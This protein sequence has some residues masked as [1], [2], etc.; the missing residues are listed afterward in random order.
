MKKLT[1]LFAFF[2]LWMIPEIVVSQ[3]RATLIL[4][5]LDAEAGATIDVPITVS[6]SETIA[7][8]QFV[9]EYNSAVLTFVSAELGSATDGFS[10]D[11]N[12]DLP[13][14]PTGQ[15]TDEN[16]LTQVFGDLSHTFTG[17]S[18]QVVHLKF[19]VTG[20]P[21]QYSPLIFDEGMVRTYLT[22]VTFQDIYGSAISFVNGSLNFVVPVEL[23]LFNAI[24][25]QGQ[26]LLEW[27]TETETNNFGFEIQRSE[28]GSE[29]TKIGFIPGRQTTSQPQ[30]YVYSDCDIS[31]GDFFYRLKQIDTD[32]SF[33]FSETRTV[34]IAAPK[35]VRMS[36]CYPNPFNPATTIPYEIGDAGIGLQR[37]QLIIFN[38]LGEKVRVLVNDEMRAGFY[39][40]KWDGKN[41]HGDR[42]A[43]GTYLGFLSVNGRVGQS[44]K[45]TFLR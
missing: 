10:L 11:V 20:N 30:R 38:S 22:T 25:K 18:K 7:A 35:D 21:G 5:T 19:T 23:S 13:Y 31:S 37:V 33:H 2:V 12:A 42:V 14:A 43:S 44:M 16:V 34:T 39:S 36:G 41:D 27:R 9:V 29:F 32:G 45:M 17:Q 26:V 15:G 8:A 28:T 24:M 1:C 4:P 3:T 40:V 6:T